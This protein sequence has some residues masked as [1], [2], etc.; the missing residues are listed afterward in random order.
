MQKKC[1]LFGMHSGFSLILL[2]TFSLCL[3]H[4]VKL[5]ICIIIESSQHPMNQGLLTS[6]LHR[7]EN[8]KLREVKKKKKIP[9]V[10]TGIVGK[11]QSLLDTGQ[12]DS[13][14]CAHCLYGNLP[15]THSLIFCFQENPI[16]STLTNILAKNSSNNFL[17]SKGSPRFPCQSSIIN[18]FSLLEPYVLFILNYSQLPNI[19]LCHTS[20][21]SVSLC[22]IF[23]ALGL[24]PLP[25]ILRTS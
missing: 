8:P 23:P 3:R 5:F 11:Q 18:H 4:G 15:P 22:L 25:D 14:V 16:Y 24:L 6:P 7:Q 2:I 13:K 10:A 19:I 20:N 12:C 9:E 1:V 17:S 21:T